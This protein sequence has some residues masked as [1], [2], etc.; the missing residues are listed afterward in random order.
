MAQIKYSPH[1][2]NKR[3]R[4]IPFLVH[5]YFACAKRLDAAATLFLTRTPYFLYLC[6]LLHKI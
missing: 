6:L 5:N 1:K 3:D 2:A 4:P